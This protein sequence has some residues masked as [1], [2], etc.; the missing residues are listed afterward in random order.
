MEGTQKIKFKPEYL[1]PIQEEIWREL[2]RLDFIHMM[3]KEWKN[4]IEQ[5]FCDNEVTNLRELVSD[6]EEYAEELIK[7]FK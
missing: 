6:N 1:D 3:D 2:R 5:S 4:A 7:R